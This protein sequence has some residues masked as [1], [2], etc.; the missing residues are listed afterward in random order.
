MINKNVE[1]CN[2]NVTLRGGPKTLI[3]GLVHN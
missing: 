3:W 1:V 2:Q